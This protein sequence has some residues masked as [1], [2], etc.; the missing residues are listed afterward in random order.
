MQDI[1][2]LEQKY[3]VSV[4]GKPA[5]LSPDQIGELIKQRFK[6]SRAIM[7]LFDQFEVSPDRLDDLTIIIVD[8]DKKYAETDGHTMKLSPTL[9]EGGDFF[10][11]NFFVPAHEIIH[12][13]SRIKEQ[14]AYFNDPEETLGFVSSIA[15]EIEQGKQPDEIYNMIYPKVQWHF[16]DERDAREFFENMIERAVEILRK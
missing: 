13:L 6:S 10:E 5:K 15:Y 14:D 4:E 11:S 9:F 8:L 12:Y 7:E 16:H 3:V 1:K 2:D